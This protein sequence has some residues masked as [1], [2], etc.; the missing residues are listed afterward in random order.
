MND[1]VLKSVDHQKSIYEIFGDELVNRAPD[2]M[3]DL[4]QGFLMVAY[5]DSIIYVNVNQYGVV[6]ESLL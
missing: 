1:D 6:D 4:L 5:R 3:V 2:K